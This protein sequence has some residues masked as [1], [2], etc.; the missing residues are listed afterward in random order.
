MSNAETNKCVPNYNIPCQNCEQT[1]TVD[2]YTKDG[3]TLVH[4][5]ELCGPCCWGEAETINPEN[6]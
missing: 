2:I 6:W 5:T 1:P 4:Q 3:E